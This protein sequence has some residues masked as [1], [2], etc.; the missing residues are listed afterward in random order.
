MQYL[1]I[2]NKTLNLR[3]Q[4]VEESI[5]RID[6]SY[7]TK[8]AF[9][10]LLETFAHQLQVISTTTENTNLHSINFNTFIDNLLF[11]FCNIRGVNNDATNCNLSFLTNLTKYVLFAL[12]KY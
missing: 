7:V 12:Y 10:Q 5:H 1:N 9:T 6:E 4:H 3:L 2:I 11:A 8:Q